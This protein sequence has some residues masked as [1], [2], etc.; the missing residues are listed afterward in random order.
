MNILQRILASFFIITAFASCVGPSRLY[1]FNDQMPSVQQLDSLRSTQLQRV[2]SYDR[3]NITVSS[4]D[5]SLTSYLNPFNLN[6]T[7]N[8]ASQQLSM[9]YLVNPQGYIEFP[10]IGQVA[11]V[12]LTTV[13]VS[14]LLRKKLSYFYKDLFVNVNINGRIYFMNG[15]QGTAIQMFNERMTIFEALSQSGLQDPYDVKNGVW[16]VRED[17]G[18]RNFVQLDLN[19]KKIFESPYYY[20]QSNDLVYLKPG[21]Y[22]GILHPSSPFRGILTLLGSLAAILLAI[23]SL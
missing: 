22:S 10:Q 20:L 9:G 1:L 15:R 3:L 12:G 18:R 7:Q 19:S 14:E 4:T 2:K 11:V 8:N 21:K 13:E 6:Q 16:L 5:P 17:S 23:K